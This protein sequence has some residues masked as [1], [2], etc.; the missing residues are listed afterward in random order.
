MNE[1]MNFALQVA[2]LEEQLKRVMVDDQDGSLLLKKIEDCKGSPSP[3]IPKHLEFFIISC[4]TI[5]LKLVVIKSSLV[6]IEC[7]QNAHFIVQ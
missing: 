4:I 7:G 2:E 3:Y 6:C 1:K 5:G